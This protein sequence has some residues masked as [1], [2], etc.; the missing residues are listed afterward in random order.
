MMRVFILVLAIVM[1][2]TV[3]KAQETDIGR[4]MR[5]AIQV[6]WNV[7]TNNPVSVTVAFHLD[8]QG[9]VVGD[10]RL[11]E[12]E[13]GTVADTD[14]AYESARRAILRCQGDGYA[15]PSSDYET[16]QSVQ[17]TFDARLVETR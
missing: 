8:I 7:G 13:G 9:R 6:C 1:S 4:I 11:V 15:L 12:S 17:I 3:A 2:A 16:W 10:T 14:A 5:K